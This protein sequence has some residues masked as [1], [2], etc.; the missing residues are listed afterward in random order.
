M[1]YI[2]SRKQVARRKE[3][4]LHGKHKWEE[5]V[6]LE[7][8]LWHTD[9]Q[10]DAAVEPGPDSQAEPEAPFPLAL[11]QHY[12]HTAQ[13]T[14]Y[15]EEHNG[16]VLQCEHSDVRP[17][18]NDQYSLLLAL[19]VCSERLKVFSD[20]V[21][22]TEASEMVP[23]STVYVLNKYSVSQEKMVGKVRYKGPLSGAQ[24][25]WF[26]VEL[27]AVSCCLDSSKR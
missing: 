12:S 14:L 22:M 7:G 18:T 8:S 19:S 24:G 4:S 5:I 17:L 16:A 9:I 2:L 20:A 23:G 11:R 1:H 3:K 26:G 27:S 25:I 13:L 6:V 21:W 15:S 10:E